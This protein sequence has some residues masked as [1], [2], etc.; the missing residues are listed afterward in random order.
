MF[1]SGQCKPPPA[2]FMPD[3]CLAG[4]AVLLFGGKIKTIIVAK[5]LNLSRQPLNSVKISNLLVSTK[6]GQCLA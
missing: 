5:F 2:C 6:C 1:P 3:I 4:K